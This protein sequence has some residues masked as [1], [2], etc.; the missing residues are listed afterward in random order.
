MK[1][2]VDGWMGAWVDLCEV[3]DLIPLSV[4]REDV[5]NLVASRAAHSNACL[6]GVM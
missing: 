3:S 6:F 4:V 5:S 2:K 1:S